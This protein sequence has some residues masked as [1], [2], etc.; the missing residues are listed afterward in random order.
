MWTR[1][2]LFLVL[3]VIYSSGYC[4]IARLDSIWMANETPENQKIKD[5]LNYGTEMQEVVLD[6]SIFYYKWAIELSN[7]LLNSGDISIDEAK[8]IKHLKN[9]GMRFLGVVYHLLGNFDLAMEN[10]IKS[11]QLSE[12]IGDKEGMSLCYG[13]IG[14]VHVNLGNFD[15]AIEYFHQSLRIFEELGDKGSL[16]ACINNIGVIYHHLTELEKAIEYYQKAL[17]LFIELG[18]KSR[19]SDCYNN[20]GLIK[21][22]QGRYD[23]AITYYQRALSVFEEINDMNGRIT[24]YANISSLNLAIA[25]SVA[26]TDEQRRIHLNEALNHGQKAFNLARQIKSIPLESHIVENLMKVHKRLGNFEKSL[27][28]AEAFIVTKDKMYSEEKTKVI[29]EMHTKF[30]SEKKQQEIEKQQLI[31][32]RNK[33]EFSRQRTQMNLF[34]T[35]LA[36]LVII[37]L[38]VSYAY[39]QK[40][41]HSIIISE[42]NALLEQY[43]EEIKATSE[44]LSFQN[45]QL[46]MQNEKISKQH[47]EIEAQRNSLANLA[48]ELQDK[49]EEVEKQK[50]KLAQQNKEI[51][52]SIIYAQR[53]QSAVLPSS[54]MLRSF[55]ADHFVLYKP[56]S[57]VSGDFYWATRINDLIVFCVTDCTGHGVPGAFMSMMG[58]SFLNEIVRKEE[59]TNAASVLNE[60]RN[61]VIASMVERDNE[62]VMFDGMDIGLCVLNTKT[63][64]FQFAGANIPCWIAASNTEIQLHDDSIEHLYGLIEL[65]PNRMPIG[66]FE[67]MEPFKH[68]ELKLNKG[69]LVFISSDGY[70]DQ[71]GGL[72]GKKYQKS[73]LIELIAQ[74]IRLPLE[75]QKMIYSKVFDDW[76][77]EK[78][79]ID[80]VTILCVKV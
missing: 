79:Q 31:I 41:N 53:I 46:K 42:K 5:I 15:E 69:D 59:V 34:I 55:F 76:K 70:T 40:Y 78:N 58:V 11:L 48:W 20:I 67:K 24:A 44:A 62:M 63:L 64:E 6:S 43:N 32:E 57:I 61:H 45:E 54:E 13:N 30:E 26:K 65:K 19:T 10:Y 47:D 16:A 27:E 29:A 33:I 39:R 3:L 52:D 2:L 1:Y 51:T 18:N 12:E 49:S 56:K 17:V 80:D 50:N 9:K 74:N 37:V 28:F 35:A 72:R 66:R 36:L 75:E 21:Q 22:N 71:F 38:I 68:V 60:L 25:D 4:Q 14:N 77:G 8:S 7:S 23:E 73:S